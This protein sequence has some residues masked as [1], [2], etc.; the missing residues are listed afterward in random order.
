MLGSLLVLSGTA[1]SCDVLDEAAYPDLQSLLDWSALPG[2]FSLQLGIGGLLFSVAGHRACVFALD[3][4]ASQN[5]LQYLQFLHA[6][7]TA[8][9]SQAKLITGEPAVELTVLAGWTFHP[10]L[11]S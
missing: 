8:M 7:C 6:C 3:Q 2:P 4:R 1:H 11:L 10:I 9:H 5:Q